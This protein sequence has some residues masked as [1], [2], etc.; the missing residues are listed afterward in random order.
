MEEIKKENKG[1]QISK[2]KNKFSNE[3]NFIPPF[4][5]RRDQDVGKVPGKVP[6]H[7][8]SFLP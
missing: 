7:P 6:S 1:I 8:V 5:P 4:T 3:K 2:W